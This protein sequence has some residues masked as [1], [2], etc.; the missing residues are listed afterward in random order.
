VAEI[1]IVIRVRPGSSRSRVGGSYGPDGQLVV[2]VHAAPV[3]GAAN[4][5]VIRALA[6]ALGMRARQ[7]R[8]VSGAT[9]RTK[10]VGVT[11]E[12][13]EAN[14]L[15]ERVQ[16]LRDGAGKADPAQPD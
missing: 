7:L 2:A 13:A 14:D 9:S 16:A 8:I 1:R 12:D 5:A 10:V 11:V 6:T 4:E 15:G 3:D